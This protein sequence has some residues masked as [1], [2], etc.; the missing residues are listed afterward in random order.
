[1][2]LRLPYVWS[3]LI[4][5][6]GSKMMN[7]LDLSMSSISWTV[8][9]YSQERN[10][11]C[12]KTFIILSKTSHTVFGFL[13]V[14]PRLVANVRISFI[15]ILFFAYRTKVN[16]ITF[17]L[18]ISPFW[19]RSCDWRDL[20][21]DWLIFCDSFWTHVSRSS[22]QFSIIWT[23]F[24]FPAS[25]DGN[26]GVLHLLRDEADVQHVVEKGLHP[27]YISVIK[28]SSQQFINSSVFCILYVCPLGIHFFFVC[29]SLWRSFERS[30]RVNGIVLIG[31]SDEDVISFSP[32]STCPNDGSG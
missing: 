14:L 5:T 16:E 22:I 6:I 10:E 19:V 2:I 24:Y 11:V 9:F 8:L 18:Y 26:V 27:P 7:V 4:V 25:A 1:M 15:S 23:S 13:T 29:R 17:C 20:R 12:A 30:G 31:N 3:L 21:I 32:D 28:L